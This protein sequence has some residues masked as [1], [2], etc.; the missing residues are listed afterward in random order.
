VFVPDITF[1]L[2]FTKGV[3]AGWASVSTPISQSSFP[4]EFVPRETQQLHHVWIRV[5]D[6]SRGGIEN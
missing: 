1:P 4:M 3:L 2:Q 6:F 5:G